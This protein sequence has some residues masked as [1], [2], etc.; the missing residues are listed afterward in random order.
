M[1]NT[2]L[3]NS[4]RIDSIDVFR[5]VTMFFMIFVNDL[6]TLSNVP[7]WLKHAHRDVDALG[8]ADVIFPAFLFIVGL[9][10]P[11]A[12]SKRD[13]SGADNI[14]IVKHISTRTLALVVMGLFMV[15]MK[16][17]NSS[18]MPIDKYVWRILMAVGIFLVWMHYRPMSLLNQKH[19]KAL[20]VAGVLILVGLAA[21]Y[22]AG[23]ADDPQW[24][25]VHW[26][27]ILGSIGWAYLVC[28]LLYMA[29]GN[30]LALVAL[31]VVVFNLFNIQEFA[32]VGGIPTIDFVVSASKYALVMA[33]VLA[34]MIYQRLSA[35]G[36]D[37]KYFY[38]LIGLGVLFLVYGFLLRPYWGGISKIRAT[39]SFTGICTGIS[40]ISLALFYMLVDKFKVKKWADSIEPAGT[41]TLTCYLL[42]Y[43]I[44]PVLAIFSLK[45]P[46]HLTTGMVGLTK[47]LIF[48]FLVIYLT[49]L[50][51][52]IHIKLKV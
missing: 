45:L 14:K 28:S 5:A 21:V 11:L 4:G 9:S 15:N 24:M 17:L 33:G 47:S 30:R 52:K 2:N 43:I 38:V 6:W 49:G 50:L 42:P 3:A 39:P 31:S 18:L 44:Y 36:E 13:Q 16:Y 8:F 32:L 20:Q 51:G 37:K 7:E 12:L 1:S 34:T 40:F 22:Q 29:I 19:V 46:E 27:G 35:A 23:K 10:I 48:A 25:K 41:S 26:W